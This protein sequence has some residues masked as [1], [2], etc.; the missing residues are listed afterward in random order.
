MKVVIKKATSTDAT[1]IALLAQITFRQAFSHFWND[2]QVL[3]N[4]FKKTFSVEK[5][6]SSLS[7]SNNM[8]WIA[9]ADD[10]PVGYAK[11][12]INCPYEKLK[13]PQPAQLQ[14]IYLLQDY[15]AQGIG[16]QLQDELFKEVQKHHIKTLWLAVWDENDKAIRFYERYGFKKETTY[17]YD[18]EKMSIDYQVMT[19][20]FT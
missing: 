18:F 4:Y 19:K 15:I 2:E 9:Y 1:I 16:E 17:H 6:R 8:F 12:K 11:L 7:K 20:L 10:L 13:D 3:R 14:K 5:M